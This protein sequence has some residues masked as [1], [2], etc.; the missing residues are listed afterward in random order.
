MI[1]L[2]DKYHITSGL[3][4]GDRTIDVTGHATGLDTSLFENIVALKT[5][6]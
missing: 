3:V 4:I 1:Y 5:K 2:R 6:Q